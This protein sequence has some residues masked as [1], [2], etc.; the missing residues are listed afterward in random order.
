M[1]GMFKVIRSNIIN[2]KRKAEVV[3]PYY[4]YYYFNM[5]SQGDAAAKTLQW[6]FTQPG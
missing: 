6:H 2:S 1:W 5:H 3:T 4:E